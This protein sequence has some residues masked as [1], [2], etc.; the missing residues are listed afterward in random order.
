MS[1]K[2]CLVNIYLFS[3]WSLH[4]LGLLLGV[5]LRSN[6]LR[7]RLLTA[8]SVNVRNQFLVVWSVLQVWIRQL[9]R[10]QLS[11]HH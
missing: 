8:T 1:N 7:I 5:L 6:E 11:K 4:I 2:Y 10:R 9:E 3:A